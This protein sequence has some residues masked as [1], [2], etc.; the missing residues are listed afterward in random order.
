MSERRVGTYPP[1]DLTFAARVRS[2]V[3]RA[4]WDL[5]SAEGVAL[6]QAV[7]RTRY[8]NATVRVDESTNAG[9]AATLMVDVYRDGDA[10]AGVAASPRRV[11]PTGPQVEPLVPSILHAWRVAS[12]E[13]DALDPYSLE[14]LDVADRLSHLRD[15]HQL[16]VTLG[17]DR[18]TVVRFLDDHGL[19]GVVPPSS[20]A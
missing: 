8:P 1:A 13:Q 11:S 20:R 14:G 10:G 4:P 5:S 9:W 18:E 17:T 15:A 6:L 12:R 7:V 16:A 3:G 19:G 2:I